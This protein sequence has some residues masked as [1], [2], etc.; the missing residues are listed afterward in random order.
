MVQYCRMVVGGIS[1]ASYFLPSAAAVQNLFFFSVGN[2]RKL[3]H[4]LSLN[5]N[6]CW[7]FLFDSA[8][9][10]RSS[11]AECVACHGIE[12]WEGLCLA[13]LMPCFTWW[14]TWTQSDPPRHR[15]HLSGTVRTWYSSKQIKHGAEWEEDDRVQFLAEQQNHT[16]AHIPVWHSV[17]PSS[18]LVHGGFS[19]AL[20]RIEWQISRVREQKSL[21]LPM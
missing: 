12:K 19:K 7:N 1:R 14:C 21:E 8:W 2:S 13:K 18:A 16:T 15:S 5:L 17:E 9:A 3:Y 4:L 11:K 6:L 10:G 20:P